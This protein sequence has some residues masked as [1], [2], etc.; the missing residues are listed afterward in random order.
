M[1]NKERG[2]LRKHMLDFQVL[3]KSMEANFTSVP[4]KSTNPLLIELSQGNS[5]FVKGADERKRLNGFYEAAKLRNMQ[6]EIT[7]GELSGI[8]GYLVKFVE[9]TKE[10]K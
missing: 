1:L 7:K 5:I 6:C 10:E 4:K 2:S 3:D 9:K 8:V